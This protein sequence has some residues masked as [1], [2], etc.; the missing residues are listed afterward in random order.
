MSFRNGDKAR[1]GRL[2]KQRNANRLK[3]R[4]LRAAIEVEK[5][6]GTE[7]AGLVTRT[8]QVIG[9]ALGTI[10]AATHLDGPDA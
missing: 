4:A 3:T 8:A 10:A 9:S 1:S 7:P 6:A 2:R 5:P